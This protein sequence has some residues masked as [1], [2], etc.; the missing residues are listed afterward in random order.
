MAYTALEVARAIVGTS[1]DEGFWLSRQRLQRILW[2]AWQDHFTRFGSR[3]FDDERFTAWRSG[4]VLESVHRDGWISMTRLSLMSGRNV[5]DMDPRTSV[6]LSDA[7]RRYSEVE[8]SVLDEL[9][10]TEGTIWAECVRNGYGSEIPFEMI[11]ERSTRIHPFRRDGHW[12]SALRMV[13][14]MIFPEVD[15]GSSFT[16]STALGYLYGA[17][18][19]LT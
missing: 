15:F 10:S 5:P 13:L 16:N 12:E 7:V 8:P 11:E 9:T 17:V 3:L 2:L 1:V 6:F 14:L 4:P 18:P 19:F